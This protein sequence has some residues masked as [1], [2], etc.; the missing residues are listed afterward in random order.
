MGFKLGRIYVLKFEDSALEGAE[1]RLKS[2]SVGTRLELAVPVLGYDVL[3]ERLVEHVI[4]WNLE[5]PDG[6]PLPV[7]VEAVKEH[8][9]QVVLDRIYR[10]W[11]RAMTGV[12]TPLDGPSKDGSKPE[13]ETS[14]QR[15]TDSRE[16]RESEINWAEIPASPNQ[17]S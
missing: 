10:E 3:I 8:M 17:P 4:D 1:V 13:Q 14:E 16:S 9:E 5:T 7:T 2:T 12:T 11:M 6:E 15:S